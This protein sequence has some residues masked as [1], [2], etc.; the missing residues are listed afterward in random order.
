MRIDS[1]RVA[2]IVA[3]VGFGAALVGAP[4]ASAV[5]TP[6][7]VK[8]EGISGDSAG[9]V[10]GAPKS[11]K[12][13]LALAGSIVG[14][15]SLPPFPT[16]VTADAPEKVLLN[17]GQREVT[18]TYNI[19]V[20][21]QVASLLR[22]KLGVNSITASSTVAGVQVTGP[23][24]ASVQETATDS[25]LDLTNPASAVTV[26][27]K[28]K[29]D[30]TK[31]GRIFYRPTPM[32]MKLKIDASVAGVATIGT[33]TVACDTQGVIASTVVQVPGTPNTPAVVDGGTVLGGTSAVIPLL[34]RG[35]F[36]PD[37]G[38]PILADTLRITSGVGGARIEN[39]S[40]IQPTDAAG[41][42]YV[43]EVEVCAA[44]RMTA[45]EPGVNELQ[46]LTF[47]SMYPVKPGLELFNPHPLGMR[48]SFNGEE[49]AEI[50]LSSKILG[51]EVLGQFLPPS[52]GT[53]RKAIEDL[54]SVEPGDVKVTRLSDTSYQFEF[55]GKLAEADQPEIAL[56][57]WR[58][59]LDYSAYD[60]IFKAINDLTGGG[61]GGGGEPG[62]PGEPDPGATDLTL[63]EL[64]AQLQSGQIA[65]EAFA[66]KFGSALKNSIVKALP[67]ADILET[68]EQMFPRKPA[69]ATKRDGEAMIK[70]GLTGLL[71]ANFIVQVEA[72]PND[73]V[74]AQA[75]RTGG[76]C[77]VS[78]RTVKVRVKTVRK[79]NGR[80]RARY[81]TVK[82]VRTV[83]RGACP[84][85][86]QMRSGKLVVTNLAVR[87]SKPSTQA[88]KVTIT[89]TAGGAKV[90]KTLSVSRK[91][92]TASG[93]LVLPKAVAGAKRITVKIGGRGV[94]AQSRTLMPI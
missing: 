84:Q 48:L 91:T 39:G 59:Q 51:S 55:T 8:C 78:G 34:S 16:T 88:K 35:D 43:N 36:L 76:P 87:G 49:T 7:T 41:G 79:V 26:S 11:S 4:A 14:I 64:F 65:A 92:A 6:I 71:C 37:D 20:P 68:L 53:V 9:V 32:T 10:S 46:T 2:A 67:I 90:T 45:D 50:P 27:M 61:G 60:A 63:D 72:T 62:E 15:P 29:I 13:I 40:L 74:A 3:A 57:D 85:A 28:V 44:P 31:S 52:A 58:T 81:R 70:G 56:S 80:K 47:P 73:Q 66:A 30:S 69:I 83:K 94:A 1:K 82:V 54:P 5:T 24:S 89:V 42:T 21:D 75:P 17:S 86:L 18:L 19:R 12:E 25:V 23:V 22:D 33:A 38:N 93:E 77:R